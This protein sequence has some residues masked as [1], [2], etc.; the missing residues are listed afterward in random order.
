MTR[1]L[2][3]ANQKGGVGKTTTSV[4]LAASLA[5]QGKCTLLVDLDP[6][7]NATMGCGVDKHTLHASTCEWLLGEVRLGDIAT[8]GAP[9]MELAPANA[10]LTAAELELLGSPDR[11][12]RLRG[13]LAGEV[14]RF[15]YVIMDCP[16]SLNVLTVNALMAAD[17]RGD[18]DPVRVL[19]PRGPDG[20]ARHDRR[21][22]GAGQ[23]GPVDRGHFANHV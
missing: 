4:N 12:A 8:P 18:P 9:G 16:P 6:Q 23:P 3:V 11:N 15:D 5:M 10:D 13:C 7:G 19:R 22:A 17:A 20:A 14:Q 21:R 1:L 2:A